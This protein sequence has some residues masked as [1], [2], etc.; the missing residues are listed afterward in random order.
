[1]VDQFKTLSK[2]GFEE[3]YEAMKHDPNLTILQ[4]AGVEFTGEPLRRSSAISARSEGFQYEWADKIPGVSHSQRSFDAS[5]D[6]LRLKGGGNWIAELR[7]KGI[8][9]ENNPKAYH[10]LGRLINYASGRGSFGKGLNEFFAKTNPVWFAPRFRASRVQ[11]I[12]TAFNPLASVHPRVRVIAM[13]SL[14]KYYGG[15][16]SVLAMGAAAGIWKVSLDPDDADFMKAKAGNEH[17]DFS[18]G[19]ANDFRLA[20]RLTNAAIDKAQGLE[21][22]PGRSLQDMAEQ[23]VGSTLSPAGG[24]V[25]GALTGEDF[26][27]DKFKPIDEA[28]KLMVPMGIEGIYEGWQTAGGPSAEEVLKEGMGGF[29]GERIKQGLIGAAK[30]SPG[31]ASISVS[32]YKEAPEDLQATRALATR[33]KQK[34]HIP[35]GSIPDEPSPYKPLK[36]ALETDNPRDARLALKELL[37]DT[38]QQLQRQGKPIAEA[39]KRIFEALKD[40]STRPFTGSKDNEKNFEK[41]LTFAQMGQYANAKRQMD[42]SWGRFIGLWAAQGL[43]TPRNPATGELLRR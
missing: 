3:A 39:D 20:A 17:Y 35:F 16:A 13:R 38:R 15:V 6:L 4:N 12:H 1:M 36:R 30:A 40:W 29:T 37:A 14:G 11:L 22:R 23:Y 28:F 10:D 5:L 7:S 9:P 21:A 2:V 26:K 42:A 34:Q 33:W 19:E 27:G 25:K 24:Y 32:S 41:S 31:L 43:R 18:G 8:T